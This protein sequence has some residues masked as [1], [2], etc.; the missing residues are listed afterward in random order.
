MKSSLFLLLSGLSIAVAAPRSACAEDEWTA[1][2]DGKSLDG[3]VQRGGDAQYTVEDG[4]I[5]GTTVPKTPN[6]FLCTEKNY[7]D[8]V[9]EVEFQVD[10]ELNS[11]VQFRSESKA[12]YKDGRVHGYQCEIDPSDRGWTGGIYGEGKRNWLAPL[13]GNLPA[14]YAFRQ[15]EWNQFRIVAIGNQLRTWINGVPAARLD[16]QEPVMEG[17]IALQVHGVGNREEPIQVRWRNIR[18]REIADASSEEARELLAA[19][20]ETAETENIEGPIFPKVDEIQK[21][22]EGFKFTE[23]PALGPDGRIYFNDIP[24][25]RTH[26]YDP[27]SGKTTIFR[28]S[29]GRANGLFFLPSNALVAC[30]GGN[31]QLTRQTVD[32]EITVLADTYEGKKLNSPN[33][34]VIDPVGGIYFTDPHY[35]RDKSGLELGVEAVYYLDR[36]RKITQVANDLTKPNGIIFSPDYQTL[37]IADPGAE[38]IWAYDVKGEGKIENRRKF[39]AVGSDGM[40][41]DTAGNIYVTWKGEVIAFAPDG[42]EAGRLAF[43]EGPANCLLVGNTLYVTARTGFYAVELNATGLLP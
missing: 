37:Y 32:G 8:F 31:R 17:F 34:L 29:T 30:E 4:V 13:G 26:V 36:K 7:S 16:D 2:F 27:E 22:A 25:E 35:G 24:N 6:S 38:T 1:L 42:T 3:W 11:G 19:F 40:T 14:R 39:A 10:P 5:V 18:I 23:G 28:E 20:D 41:V 21:L 43:P 33:D 12:D 9:L 15:G